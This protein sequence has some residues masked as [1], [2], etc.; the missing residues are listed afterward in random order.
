MATGMEQLF[1]L[2]AVIFKRL[3][4]TMDPRN[5]IFVSGLLNIECWYTQCLPLNTYPYPTYIPMTVDGA[6]FID[7]I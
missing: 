7:T 6:L 3:Q 4:A 2:I 1:Q 5:S